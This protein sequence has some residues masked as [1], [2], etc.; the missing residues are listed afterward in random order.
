MKTFWA[1]GS[2]QVGFE[3]QRSLF[4]HGKVLVPLQRKFDMHVY[5][6]NG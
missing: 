6:S 3:L 2:W 1:R 4:F 5:A